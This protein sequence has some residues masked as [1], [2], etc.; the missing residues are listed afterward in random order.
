MKLFHES[1][2]IFGG[3]RPSWLE[4]GRCCRIR[5]RR[6]LEQVEHERLEAVVIHRDPAI[7]HLL[8]RNSLHPLEVADDP[9]EQREHAASLANA[10][11]CDKPGACS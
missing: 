3:P 9:F 1:A 8:L 2:E 11:W 7:D 6:A 5:G 10:H 4:T